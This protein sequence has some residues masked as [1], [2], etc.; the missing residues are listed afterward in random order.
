[1]P[2]AIRFYPRFK[3]FKAGSGQMT[4]N[5][6]NVPSE[7]PEINSEG[8][9][10]EKARNDVRGEQTHG[11]QLIHHLDDHN[12]YDNVQTKTKLI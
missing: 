1:M 10:C 5:G 4:K 8:L 6:W 11:R 7:R 3:A 12:A 2:L 9:R